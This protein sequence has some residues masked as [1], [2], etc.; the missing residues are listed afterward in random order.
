MN[1]CM[2][3]IKHSNTEQIL[4]QR[5]DE[6]TV[7]RSVGLSVLFDSVYK[8]LSRWDSRTEVFLEEPH[9]LCLS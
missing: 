6:P 1:L 3:L 5:E 7:L 9:A 2:A 8:R 4:A